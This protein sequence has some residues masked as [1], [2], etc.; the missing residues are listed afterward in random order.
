MKFEF[1]TTT[2]VD[3]TAWSMSNRK[4]EQDLHELA[5]TDLSEIEV[6]TYLAD[7]IKELT[8]PIASIKQFTFLLL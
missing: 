7:M 1:T 8:K 3:T 5:T 6:E 2:Q 4:L